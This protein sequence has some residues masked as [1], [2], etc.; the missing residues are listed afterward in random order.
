MLND[1]DIYDELPFSIE[2]GWT[3][4][5]ALLNKKLPVKKNTARG[6]L[7]SFLPSSFL[8]A[9]LL[10][11]SLQL[12]KD[13]LPLRFTIN[14]L[15]TPSTIVDISSFA[16]VNEKH[17]A[18]NKLNRNS[19]IAK[20]KIVDDGSKS[21][22]S[23][24]FDPAAT[25][26]VNERIHIKNIIQH[27]HKNKNRSN[28]IDITPVK[29]ETNFPMIMVPG[30]KNKPVKPW[31]LSA[32]IGVNMAAGKHQNLQPYPVAEIK[33]NLDHRLF[34]AAGLSLF[35]PAPGNV[36]GV[37]KTTYVNDTLNN[38]RLYNETVIY[39]QL[40]YA[41]V[42][43]F[44]GVNIYKKILVQAGVQA[45]FLLS[46]SEKRTVQPYDFQMNNID[47]ADNLPLV[48]LAANPHETF[49][50]RVRNI[51]Y[52]FITGVKY[53][54]NKMTAGLFYQHGLQSTGMGNINGKSNNQ[55]FTMNLLYQIR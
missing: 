34:V 14:E 47:R 38:F 51:D 25:V 26:D 39:E 43:L 20:N 32:G 8:F 12:S 27:S 3:E 53:K 40:R 29:T 17:P 7:L 49:D 4:M 1:Q 11:S 10:F 21:E 30:K 52:R 16:P 2:E 6:L 9:I 18:I 24:E 45:S 5:Q 33:Y 35:S 55:L 42:P 50:V 22:T 37:H 19:I 28:I 44:L 31:E 54:H 36:S 23:V 46:R 15:H 41:D 48:G 13:S